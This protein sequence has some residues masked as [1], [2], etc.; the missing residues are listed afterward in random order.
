MKKLF[1]AFTLFLFLSSF[2]LAGPPTPPP[3]AKG[4]RVYTVATLPAASTNLNLAVIV[5]DSDGVGDCTVGGQSDKTVCISDGTDWV[6]TGDGKGGAGSGSMTTVESGDAQVGGADIVILDFA[7]ADFAVTESPNTEINVSLDVTPS[8]GNATIVVE[9]DAVQVKYDTTDFAESTAG[10]IL[11]TDPTIA[12]SLTVGGGGTVITDA[13]ITDDGTLSIVATTDVQIT[14]GDTLIIGENDTDAG[15]LKI[16][17]DT[18]GQT[19]GGLIRINTSADH[20]TTTEYFAISASS[21]DLYI[22]TDDDADIMKFVDATSVAFTLPVDVG[23]DFSVSLDGTDEEITITQS[24]GTGTEDAP[25][26]FIDDSRT[27]DTA[28]ELGEATIE[29]DAEGV[30]AIN[31]LDGAVAVEGGIVPT[32]SDGCTLGTDALDFSDLW[33]AD[34]GKIDFDSGDLTLTHS[35]GLLTIAG[36]AFDVNGAAS[37]TTYDAD[38]D[39][40]VGGTEIKN[41]TLTDD[42]TF[43]I[44]TA[45]ALTITD[46]GSAGSAATL[47]VGESDGIYADIYLMADDDTSAPTITWQ[48]AP[49]DDGNGVTNFIMQINDSSDDFL[50]GTTEDEDVMKFNDDTSVTFTVPV[51]IDAASTATTYDADTD[52]TVGGTVITDNTITDDGTFIIDTVT[53]TTITDT[54]SAGDDTTL[55][56]G[57]TDNIG[58]L[59][60]LMADNNTSGPTITFEVPPDNDSTITSF[61]V[62]VN[63]SSDDL[64]IG[65]NADEDVMKFT[66]PAIPWAA[67]IM[68][69]GF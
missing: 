29:I 58:A 60:N 47:N 44:D 2:A 28:T 12:T 53:A 1:A 17:G 57:E 68:Q 19:Q 10:L 3:P 16:R 40:T 35:D 49:D 34:G 43:I 32:A 30:Y 56:I 21:D 18:T 67:L 42:G 61:I 63:D 55:N 48:V 51:D 26:I 66:K 65:S 41:N 59:V 39:F 36:G 69:K 62:Q 14:G 4:L 20:D 64:Y 23:E 52:F 54:G 9:Q 11:D 8:T 37:A 15:T 33:L 13:T 5:S 31:V 22:G 46:T 25:L 6:A 7:A 45:T 27:G 38:T 50:I 24:S